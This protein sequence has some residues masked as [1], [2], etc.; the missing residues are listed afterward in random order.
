[1]SQPTT[2]GLCVLPAPPL[3]RGRTVN[4]PGYIHELL[5]HAG[6][7]YETIE[8]EQVSEQLSQLGLLIT[9]G[10]QELDENLQNKLRQWMRANGSW[11]AIGGTCGM[12]DIFGAKAASPTYSGWGGG[13]AVA[14]RRIPYD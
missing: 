9:V 1:M 12:E 7:L 10:D 6:V 2:I 14:G 11:L 13:A 3:N 8:L 4:Y 5:L